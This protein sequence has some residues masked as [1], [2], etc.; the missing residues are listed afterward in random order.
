M[1]TIATTLTWRGA[2]AARTIDNLFA[3]RVGMGHID[4]WSSNG[5]DQ[6]WKA[7]LTFGLR[8]LVG[9]YRTESE[10]RAALEQAARR[11]LEGV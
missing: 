7:V 4:G 8:E 9:R 3:G 1:T 5:R 11:A 6:P 2:N 10:A